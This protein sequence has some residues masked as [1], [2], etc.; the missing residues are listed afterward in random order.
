MAA[1]DNDCV[2]TQAWVLHEGPAPEAC[3]GVV[4]A[5]E[6]S[7]EEFSFPA[8]DDD[9]ALVEPVYGC[10]EG[11]MTHALSR[12]PVDICRLRG[13]SRVV[14]GNSGLVRMLRPAK[15]DERLSEG[16]LCL[17]FGNAEWDE[18]GY[19][20]KALA[21][22]APGTM[23]LLAKRL[24]LHRR[25]LIPVPAATRHPL[26]R[27]AAFS[28]RFPTAWANWRVA[29]NCYRVQMPVKVAPRPHVWGWGGGTTLAQLMLAKKHG[30]QPVM[31]TSSPQRMAMLKALGIRSVDRRDFADMQ[32]DPQRYES[33]AGYRHGYK[34]AENRFLEIVREVTDGAGVSIFIDHIG[35]PVFRATL[36]ALGRQGV[37]TSAGWKH[38]MKLSS[39]RAIECIQRHTHV[40]T[41]FASHDEGV[42][43]V[44]YAEE[45]GWLPPISEESP[46]PWNA[47][48][49]LATKYAAGALSSYFPL[50]AVKP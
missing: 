11:N 6:L 49:E 3:G 7:L 20:E 17:V 47:V 19:T 9:E 27:W 35:L 40:H 34:L 36:K 45:H 25:T 39:V 12:K 33:D 29:Y 8:P 13:E 42:D 21:Y 14:F 43:A 1:D 37:V 23:G 15:N 30:C 46:F 2:S 28:A 48:P 10:W 38:G 50:Y 32:F 4:P 41:H 26:E 5:G 24:K 16:D 44:A 22:D 18:H 31:L